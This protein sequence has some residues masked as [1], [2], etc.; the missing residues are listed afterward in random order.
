MESHTCGLTGI[1]ITYLSFREVKP[2]VRGAHSLYTPED[3][4]LEESGKES[5]VIEPAIEDS[6]RGGSITQHQ[7][8][9]SVSFLEHSLCEAQNADMAGRLA[10]GQC[11]VTVC[12]R[13]TS[14]GPARS[15]GSSSRRT[16]ALGWSEFLNPLT[17]VGYPV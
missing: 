4:A 17:I 8:T 1:I 16:L 5:C 12:V 9:S 6:I 14:L 7:I 13:G 2:R 11:R 3:T 10:T 15:V